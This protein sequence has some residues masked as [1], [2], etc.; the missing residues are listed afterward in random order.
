MPMTIHLALIPS[1]RPFLGIIPPQYWTT[2]FVIPHIKALDFRTPFFH[3]FR[4]FLFFFS[5][6]FLRSHKRFW[7]LD[8]LSSLP[9]KSSSS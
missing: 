1:I 7:D 2:M 6:L 9:P 4:I 8:I 3:S 5:L